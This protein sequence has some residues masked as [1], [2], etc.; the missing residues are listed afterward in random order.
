MIWFALPALLMQRGKLVLHATTVATDDVAWCIAGQSGAGKS[1]LTAL[2][3]RGLRPVSDDV[4]AVDLDHG[5]DIV[6]LPGHTHYSLHE[7]MQTRMRPPGHP[8]LGGFQDR[9]VR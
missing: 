2:I 3:Q 9:E 4:T 8:N 6:V 5:G 7:T 1:T